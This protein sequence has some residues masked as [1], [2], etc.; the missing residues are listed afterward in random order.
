[1]AINQN[2]KTETLNESKRG[3]SAKSKSITLPQSGSQSIHRTISLIRTVAEYK[4]RGVRLSQI[5]RKAK[6]PIP[7]VHRI[8]SVLVSEGFVGYDPNSKCYHL[9]IELFKLGTIAQQFTI[10]DR[11]RVA[12]EQI[13]HESED[14]T[15]LWIRSGYDGLCIDSVI[16]EFPIHTLSINIGGRRPLGVSSGCL[17]LLAYLPDEEVKAIILANKGRYSDYGNLGEDEIW[18][19]VRRSRK[20]GYALSKDVVLKG[21]TGVGLP[22][23]DRKEKV[24]AAISVGG[25]SQRLD[26]TRRENIV[27]LIK[28][29]IQ[30]SWLIM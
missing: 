13:S 17:A 1:M 22:I 26:K 19:F 2:N 11:F 24:V 30:K 20:L 28:S 3:R 6:I 18:R 15:Y 29:E 27:K 7:T 25:I 14:T 23:Y 21:T 16:G 12:V 5:A 8:L 9:G 10:K 4:N